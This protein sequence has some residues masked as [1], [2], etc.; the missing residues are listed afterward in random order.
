MSGR[1]VH[2]E[3]PFDNGERAREFYREAFGWE[4]MELPEMSYTLVTTGPSGET[5]PT[6]PGYINGGMIDRDISPAPGPVITVDVEDINAALATIER[7]GGETLVGR[8]EVGSMGWSAYF[9]DREGNV[10]GLW[11]SVPG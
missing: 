1:I 2:F 10:I 9:R 7:L 3:I 11:E 5:G 4:L 8:T 6:E